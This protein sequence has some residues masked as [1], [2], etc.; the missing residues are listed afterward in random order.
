[1][2]SEC[3]HAT[4]SNILVK[5]NGLS[6]HRFPRDPQRKM[7]WAYLMQRP[8]G[9]K[10]KDWDTVCSEH[11]R[12]EDFDRTGQT[13]RLRPGVEP[14]MVKVPDHL[15]K[16]SKPRNTLNSRKR[17]AESDDSPATIQHSCEQETVSKPRSTLNSRKSD[18]ESDG[19]PAR[20]PHLCEQETV[21]PDTPNPHSCE[22][23]TVT[24]DTPNPD[25]SKPRSTL[26]SRKSDAE[27]DDSPAALS[28]SCEQET[29]TP[30]TPNPDFHN[31]YGTEESFKAKW[32]K[33]EQRA[34]DLDRKLHN[35]LQREKRVKLSL[36]SALK[37]LKSQKLL[38]SELQG[39]LDELKDFPHHLFNKMSPYT[40]EQQSF[41]LTLHLCGPKAYDYLSKRVNLPS[42]RTLRRWLSK[43]DGSAGLKSTVLATLKEKVAKDP[44][45]YRD[46]ALMLDAMSIPK[47]I[48]TDGQEES[49][50]FADLGNNVEPEEEASE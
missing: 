15:Q 16:A 27:S 17:A 30:D 33:A 29:V 24:P 26:N 7:R 46:V 23:E 31:Y 19:S 22:R 2:P 11:F 8:E 35:A 10:P 48:T 25:V 13:T 43:T 34:D 32:F 21:T 14:S 12:K 20:I 37:E 50:G 42:T 5:G 45:A 1:M 40:E 47:E 18:A 4:C 49:A 3:A 38:A 41:A 36:K 44:S 28:H 39:K 6:F 9:W